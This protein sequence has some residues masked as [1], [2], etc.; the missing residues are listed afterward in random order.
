MIVQNPEDLAREIRARR[1]KEG[2][3]QAKI[4][5]L[6]SVRQG[7]VS[8]F[9]NQP[10]KARLNTLFRICSSLGIELHL[11]DKNENTPKSGWQESW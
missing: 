4:A 10:D 8:N 2:L 6:A 3:S 5:N 11:I 9:E 7:T 1:K